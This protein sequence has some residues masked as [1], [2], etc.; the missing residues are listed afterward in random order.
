MSE[1]L[2]RALTTVIKRPRGNTINLAM[3]RLLAA[4]IKWQKENRQVNDLAAMG[5]ADRGSN[6]G[7]TD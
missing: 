5:W 6:P 3:L 1:V 2:D 7:P 4:L